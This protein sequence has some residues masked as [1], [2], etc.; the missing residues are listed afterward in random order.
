MRTRR[1][2][3]T[4][5]DE[6]LVRQVHALAKGLGCEVALG[7]LPRNPSAATELLVICENSAQVTAGILEE[8]ASSG[9]Q[10][11]GV[12]L[13]VRQSDRQQ[14]ADLFRLRLTNLVAHSQLSDL[15]LKATLC[16][17]LDGE[18]FGVDKYL[19]T[20]V[21]EERCRLSRSETKSQLAHAAETFASGC[22]GLNRRLVQN[23]RQASDELISNA[24]YNAPVNGDG[25]PRYRTMDRHQGVSLSPGEELDVAFVFDGQRLAVSVTDPFGSLP[26]DRVQAELARCFAQ[27]QPRTD[28]LSGGAG[29]GLFF[30]LNSMNHLVINLE[31]GRRTQIIGLLDVERSYK[32]FASKTKSFNI[33]LQA[34]SDRTPARES[35]SST[36][37]EETGGSEPRPPSLGDR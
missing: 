17:L 15:D 28:G 30:V 37:A 7:S 27:T 20:P 9:G 12:L 25:A 1:V 31:P 35:A 10:L 24:F 11:A 19:G 13:L 21:R 23:F 2:H 4:G 22:E 8:W 3:V 18:V 29:L 14:M 34:T 6:E 5:S 32:Q 26:Q 16:K 36:A 33:F